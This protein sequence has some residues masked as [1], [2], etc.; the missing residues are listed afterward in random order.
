MP[1]TVRT[2]RL[3][4]WAPALWLSLLGAAH[5][6]PIGYTAWDV[7]GNDKLLRID[8]ATGAGTVVGG[9]LGFTDIDGLSFDG[10]GGLWGVDDATNRLVQINLS[11]G[12]GTAVGAFGSGFNDMGLAY[13]GGTMFMSSTDGS[14]IGKLYTVDLNTGSASLVGS[15][16]S[17]LKVR[18]LGYYGGT[19]Y[20]WSNVDTLVTI[21]TATGVASTVGAF[22]F[23]SPTIGQDG[24]DVDPATGMLWSIAEVENR[25]Y[26]IDRSTGLATLAATSLTCNGL[27]CAGGGFN[28]L[29]I[30]PVPEPSS[31]ALSL[32]GLA[33]L[34]LVSR[35]RLARG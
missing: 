3:L 15:F 22:G 30:S 8:L 27:S 9:N 35:R 7:S 32:A 11:T 18:S 2:P 20:G 21:N 12:S 24:M 13:G 19:L 28:S 31:Q 14:N 6:G 16:G 29:A 10:S 26:R 17:G 5:A 25:T 23:P 34:L 33:G 1:A 4:R